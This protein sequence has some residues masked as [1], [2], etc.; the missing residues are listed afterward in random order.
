[1]RVCFLIVVATKGKVGKAWRQATDR[2]VEV[3]AKS[4]VREG[5]RKRGD[6]LVEFVAKLEVIEFVG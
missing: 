6:L 1:M 4:Q 2:E 5:G 3:F